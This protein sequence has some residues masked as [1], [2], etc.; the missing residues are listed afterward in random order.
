MPM[1]P[2]SLCRT[3]SGPAAVVGDQRRQ[4]DAEVDDGPVGDVARDPRRHLGAAPLRFA[5]ARSRPA[6]EA[7]GAG[8]DAVDA[9][10]PLDEDPGVTTPSGSRLPS[11][12]ISCT[13]AIVVFA[14]HRHHGPK[15]RAVMRYVRLPQRSPRSALMN[16]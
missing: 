11:R 8:R 12:T 5:I 4:A 1:T 10:D 7:A 6:A 13:V 3:T 15:L 16:A 14:G 2:F 9:D